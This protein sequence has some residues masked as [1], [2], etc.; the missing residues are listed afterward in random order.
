VTDQ[1]EEL[2]DQVP[3]V[4]YE[5]IP[6]HLKAYEVEIDEAIAIRGQIALSSE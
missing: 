2:F 4:K 5:E 3:E 6:H 1:L